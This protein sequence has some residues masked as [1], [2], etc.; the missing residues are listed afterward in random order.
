MTNYYYYWLSDTARG[1]GFHRN[2]GEK[3]IKNV[4]EEQKE[5][6]ISFEFIVNNCDTVRDLIQLDKQMRERFP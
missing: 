2:M 5:R 3:Y 4:M 1:C 6:G